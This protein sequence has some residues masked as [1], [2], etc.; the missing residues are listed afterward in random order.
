MSQIER[1]HARQILDSRG[2]PTIEVE[3]GL[4]SGAHGHAAV[5]SGASTGEFE[6]KE[7][8]D[9]GERWQG[10]GVTRAVANANGEIARAVTGMDA[11]DQRG[12]DEALVE[13]DGTPSKSRLGANAILG[14]SLAVAHAQAAEEG[15][16][17]WRYLGGESARVLPVPMM[18]VLN[19]G[20]H[21]DNKVDFQEFMVVPLGAQSFSEGLRMGTEVFHALKG[22]LRERGLGTTVGDEG[23]FAP[24]LASNEDA[25]KMLVAGIEAAGH[26]PGEDVAIALDPAASELYRDGAYVLEH[27]GRTL[28]AGEM[29]DYWADLASRYPIVSIE[30]GM[31]EE[32]WDGWKALTERLGSSVQLVGDDLFVTNTERLQRGIEEG[33]ANS[34]LIKV[35]QIGT[36]SETLQAV[37]MARE[38]GY[39]AVMSHRSGETEDVTIADLAVAT[40]CGQIK[41]GAPS[42]SDRVAKYNQL[43][44]IEEQLG[45]DAQFPGRAVFR[46]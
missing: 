34:I 42:R 6:A 17:L 20:A 21:A 36:L 14:V 11:S 44:R 4:R 32:D 9:G 19:G 5:P 24:D 43:L 1:V 23:G 26:T 8:R 35:N 18:N 28:S 15:L 31:D 3:I 40:G 2:N 38:A 10:K 25:L 45:S 46:R 13:L 30:D 27:E 41:T 39:T 16:A 12:L 29:S 7:L 33:V 22:T 37:A